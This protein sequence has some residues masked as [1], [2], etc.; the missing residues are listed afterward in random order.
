MIQ[1]KINVEEFLKPEVLCDFSVSELRKMIWLR[2]L[3]MFDAFQAICERHGLTYYLGGGTLLGAARHQGFIPWDDDFDVGMPRAD[4]EEFLKYAEA[5]L[6]AP[7]LLQTHDT[8]PGFLSCHAKL[9]N[10]ETT[11][12]RYREWPDGHD[13]CQGIFFDIFPYDN[14]PDGKL[15][16]KLHR[17]REQFLRKLLNNGP[18]YTRQRKSLFRKLAHWFSMAVNVFFPVER[19][20]RDHEKI[21]QKYNS[22]ETADWGPVSALYDNEKTY[23][24]RSDFTQTAELVFEGLQAKVPSDWDNVLRAQYGDWHQFVKSDSIHGEV[25]FD[26]DKPWTEYIDRFEEYKNYP[27]VI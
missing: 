18:L 27:Q 3:E 19:V 5:E 17:F 26:V 20:F 6:P 14:I 25:F 11:G 13:Y 9:R 8:E 10:P 15:R 1:D 21:C 2:E 24:R 22:V 4:Y 7:I 12:I 16:R 23:Y